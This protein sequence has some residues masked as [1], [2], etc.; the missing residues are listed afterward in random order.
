MGQLR[1]PQVAPPPQVPPRWLLRGKRTPWGGRGAAPG[2]TSR[3]PA[4]GSREEEVAGGRCG[5]DVGQGRQALP[6]VDGAAVGPGEGEGQPPQE[7]AALGG[8]QPHKWAQLGR[9]QRRA[10]AGERRRSGRGPGAPGGHPRPPKDRGRGLGPTERGA[11]PRRRGSA[12]WKGV[13]PHGEG[14]GPTSGGLS[15]TEG[16]W[17]RSE[18]LSPV[19]EGSAP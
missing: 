14:R 17:P 1:A 18:R 5:S 2:P 9:R 10:V 11:A 15:P 7:A 6:A 4:R 12:P 3:S 16:L 13:R 19:S 8:L